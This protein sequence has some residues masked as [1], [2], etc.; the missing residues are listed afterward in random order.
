MLEQMLH[1]VRDYFEARTR[2]WI[3]PL[4]NFSSSFS[5]YVNEK[6]WRSIQKRIWKKHQSLRLQNKKLLRVHSQIRILSVDFDEKKESAMVRVDEF[7]H[8]VYQDCGQLAVESRV[9]CHAQKWISHKG[10]WYLTEATESSERN[11]VDSQERVIQNGLFQ[12]VEAPVREAQLRTY[13]R[14]RA[15]R[16]ADLWWDQYN[17]MYR[18]FANDC[19]NYISQ[20]LLAGGLP[21]TGGQQ[22]SS[23]W[24]Y[25]GHHVGTEPWSYSWSTSHALYQYLK[26]HVH[27]V[28]C[29]YAK[30]L[31]MGDLIFYDWLGQ[32]QFHHSTIVTD[33]DENGQPLVNA[34]TDASYRRAYLYLD[35]RAWTE[36]TKY[37]FIHL[38][39]SLPAEK[40]E[41]TVKN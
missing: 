23:G 3:A 12:T 11:A 27:V 32:G 7:I 16:Y 22:R 41:N 38:P 18:V 28:Q 5:K 34:H 8:W 26:H 35:S 20:C 37:A 39:D 4:E 9:I 10:C 36:R 40:D 24:W 33:F 14:L 19:T 1:F 13:D 2:I 31:K 6:K 17:P 15:T 25:G 29:R 30:E 21:M